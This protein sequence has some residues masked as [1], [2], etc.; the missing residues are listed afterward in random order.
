MVLSLLLFI[1]LKKAGILRLGPMFQEAGADNM[2]HSPQ[3]A[4]SGE[5]HVDESYVWFIIVAGG[6]IGTLWN[7]VRQEGG[8]T[9]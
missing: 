2:E 6:T 9:T 4:Y 8:K 1:P 5:M 3:K 7:M